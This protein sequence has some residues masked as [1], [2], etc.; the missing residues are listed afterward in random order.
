MFCLNLFAKRR[1]TIFLQANKLPANEE[2]AP[3]HNEA[4][5]SFLVYS[6]L[7]RTRWDY[8]MNRACGKMKKSQAR[9]DRLMCSYD[10]FC[11]I[12]F[13]TLESACFL[14]SFTEQVSMPVAD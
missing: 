10:Y 14:F 2:S 9:H 11:E 13:C 8:Q 7:Y 4:S 5:Y 12:G 3:F 1:G 6:H